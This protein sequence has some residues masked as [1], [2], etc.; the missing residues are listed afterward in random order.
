MTAVE[1]GEPKVL[2]TL[3]EKETRDVARALSG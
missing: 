1:H 3:E 2:Y